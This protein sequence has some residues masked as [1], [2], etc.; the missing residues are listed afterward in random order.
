MGDRHL[1]HKVFTRK[2]K[3]TIY[4]FYLAKRILCLVQFQLVF[5]LVF[6]QRTGETESHHGVNRKLGCRLPQSFIIINVFQ[7][8][9]LDCETVYWCYIK[10]LILAWFYKKKIKTTTKRELLQ[11]KNKKKQKNPKQWSFVIAIF[12]YENEMNKKRPSHSIQR[13]KLKG[14]I[15]H[16]CTRLLCFS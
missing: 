16:Q 14:N 7:D 5:M 9:G 3:R 13:I 4:R 2:K 11:G 15:N 1:H 10:A 6:L 8:G 12:N